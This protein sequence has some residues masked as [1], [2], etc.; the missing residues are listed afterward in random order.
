MRGTSHCISTIAFLILSDVC[1]TAQT[2]AGL[3]DPTYRV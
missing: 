1:L 2:D 3:T